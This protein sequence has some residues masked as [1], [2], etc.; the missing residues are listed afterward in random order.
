MSL[1]CLHETPEPFLAH[2][3]EPALISETG[4]D[5]AAKSRPLDA[6][7]TPLLRGAPAIIWAK[8]GA[9]DQHGNVKIIGLGKIGAGGT[10]V[11]IRAMHGGFGAK[12][13]ATL[14]REFGPLPSDPPDRPLRGR[15][16]ELTAQ[17]VSNP[18]FWPEFALRC[19]SVDEGWR[20]LAWRSLRLISSTGRD[21]PQPAPDLNKPV[22]SQGSVPAVSTLVQIQAWRGES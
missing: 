17:V 3:H 10:V 13:R 12:V 5:S 14:A 4:R 7:L 20:R 18:R 19:P 6:P 15:S 2:S 11:Q 1:V 9:S 21:G 8:I 22:P 16:T